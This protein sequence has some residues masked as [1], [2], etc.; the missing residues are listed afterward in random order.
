MGGCI[1]AYRT[2]APEFGR[3]FPYL[4]RVLTLTKKSTFEDAMLAGERFVEEFAL[5]ETPATQ[6][7]D[8]MEQK[9]GFL[10]LMV[11]AIEGVSG[12]ACHLTELDAILI[13]RKEVEG[14]R[15]F[16]L[17]HELFH[18]LTWESMVP[19]HHEVVNEDR[20][21]RIEQ[22]AN[23][24]AAAVLMPRKLLEKYDSWLITD[25]TE[26]INRLNTVANELHVTSSALRWRLVAL[27]KLSSSVAQAIP[28][29]ALR[30]NGGTTMKEEYPKLFSKQFAE[31]IGLA[32]ATGRVSVW[33]I[34]LLLDLTFEDLGDF[35]VSHGVDYESVL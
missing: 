3:E 30:N 25:Q 15:N 32:I 34:S 19:D 1:A 9:L 12:A 28:D 31:I 35:L 18:L 26:L 14:R 8:V 29:S 2:L 33:R 17:A 7:I 23:N 16:D 10:V 27:D 11:D 13:A 6:L 5:G 22:L 20:R 4:R 24:F 21:S